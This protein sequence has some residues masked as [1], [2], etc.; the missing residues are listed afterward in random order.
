LAV[1]LPG[2]F[3]APFDNAQLQAYLGAG[4][5]VEI[6]AFIAVCLLFGFCGWVGH[7]VVKLVTFGNIDLDWRTGATSSVSRWLGFFFLLFAA[8]ALASILNR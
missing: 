6:F 1:D 4:E 8:G 2:L 7:A 5:N 3:P